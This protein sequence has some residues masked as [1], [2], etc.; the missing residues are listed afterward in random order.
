MPPRSLAPSEP[1]RLAVSDNDSGNLGQTDPNNRTLPRRAISKKRRRAV[2][3]AIVH[4]SALFRAGLR[5]T[6]ARSRFRIKAECA[7]LD[8]LPANTFANEPFLV[9][10]DITEDDLDTVLSQMKSLQDR[11]ATARII[12]LSSQCHSAELLK[13]IAAGA[14]GYLS[15]DEISG[16]A[17]LQSL[18]LALLGCVTIPRG[19]NG[20]LRRTLSRGDNPSAPI[21]IGRACGSSQSADQP[22]PSAAAAAL[23]NREQMVL[24]ELMRGAS[25]K[26]IART[27]NIAEATVKVHIKSLLR[28]IGARNRTQAAMW[29]MDNC[30]KLSIVA[31]L[32]SGAIA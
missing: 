22:M 23:S 13:F 2:P 10:I 6:L 17:L 30:S 11:S 8:D 5:H 29:A 18:E 26:H 21:E 32:L 7:V 24:R 1:R 20:T 28:K 3:I 19:L 14:S 25:N 15:T 16:D 31:G 12:L 9:L 4:R 27:I